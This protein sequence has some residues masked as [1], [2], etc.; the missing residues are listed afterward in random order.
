MNIYKVSSAQDEIEEAKEKAL[1]D[2][3]KEVRD[4]PEVNPIDKIDVNDVQVAK[5]SEDKFERL[6]R[7]GLPPEDVEEILNYS[8]NQ[9]VA[10]NKWTQDQ[11]FSDGDN[12]YNVGVIKDQVEDSVPVEVDIERYKEVL[13]ENV[14][15]EGGETLSPMDV[16]LNPTFN[17]NHV[18]HMQ[19]IRTAPLDDPIIIR[20]KNDEIVDGCHRLTRAFLE[21]RKKILAVFVEE[22]QMSKAI[23][24][25]VK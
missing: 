7:P 5:P 8:P 12:V 22:E 18:K 25:E 11:T 13:Y 3:I 20:F 21:G 15:G 24:E 6:K 17:K 23:F 2:S 9:R 10:D 1:R 4:D 19:R 14:W 16:V